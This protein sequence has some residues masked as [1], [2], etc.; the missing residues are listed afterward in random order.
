MDIITV[1]ETSV[2]ALGK[3]VV[4]FPK[5]LCPAANFHISMDPTLEKMK[6]A[7]F[8]FCKVFAATPEDHIGNDTLLD[9]YSNNE[10]YSAFWL[11]RLLFRVVDS[12]LSKVKSRI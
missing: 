9:Y 8:F 11:T 4:L 6:L 10:Y 7:K 2:Q 12:N 5:F 1:P 3:N